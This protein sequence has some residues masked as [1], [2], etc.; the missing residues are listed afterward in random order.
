MT[1]AMSAEDPTRLVHAYVDGELD[2]D[3]RPGLEGALLSSSP[4]AGRLGDMYG[5]RPVLVAILAIFLVASVG[6]A[7]AQN[8]PELIAWRDESRKNPTFSV[9]PSTPS[10]VPNH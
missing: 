3:E 9:R 6:S 5:R 7:L 4:L 8:L 2:P 1:R 10:S